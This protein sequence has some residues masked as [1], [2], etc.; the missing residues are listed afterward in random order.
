LDFIVPLSYLVQTINPLGPLQTL[1][2]LHFQAVNLL[3]SLSDIK[4]GPA[5]PPEIPGNLT[6]SINNKPLGEA[7]GNVDYPPDQSLSASGFHAGE[8]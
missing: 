3:I 4:V 6:A 5:K 7:L 2:I 1:V 8:R